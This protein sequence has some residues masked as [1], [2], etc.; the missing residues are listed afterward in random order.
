[1]AY[2]AAISYALY[3]I[4]GV[5][6]ATWLGSGDVFAKYTK[7]P[8][9][10]AVTFGLAHLSTY[11]LEKPCMEFAKRLTERKTRLAQN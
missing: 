4:H 6:T 10:F 2:I 7:R 3:I 8:L 5:L 1:M 9:L 11:Y